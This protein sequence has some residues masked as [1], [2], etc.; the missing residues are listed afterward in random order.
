MFTGPSGCGKSTLVKLLQGFYPAEEGR[1]EI[2]GRD[3][4][5]LSANE[6]RQ[7]YGVVPQDTVLFANTVYENL[8]MA[9]PH[10]GF[11]DVITACR[12]A[13]IHEVIEKSRKAIKPTSANTAWDY[14][15]GKN[16]VSPLRARCSSAR[17]Y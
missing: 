10:A 2:D 6:L 4:R 17:R 8:S 13:E 16:S 14:P 3:I 11:D 7:Y 1:I 15:A 9:S 12:M 5:H